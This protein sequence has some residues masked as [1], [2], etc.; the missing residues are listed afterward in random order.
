MHDKKLGTKIPN[1]FQHFTIA[2]FYE[3][4]TD[5]NAHNLT[6]YL[7]EPTTAIWVTEILSLIISLF[8]HAT[9]QTSFARKAPNLVSYTSGKYLD[10]DV[11]SR[12]E[13]LKLFIV[14]LRHFSFLSFDH[15]HKTMSRRH[16]DTFPNSVIFSSREEID[17]SGAFAVTISLLS[18]KIVSFTGILQISE[19]N[20]KHFCHFDRWGVRGNFSSVFFFQLR[21][22]SIIRSILAP[23]QCFVPFSLCI[24]WALLMGVCPL[25][26]SFLA[27]VI[28]QG[29]D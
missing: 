28:M 18:F 23:K 14:G 27:L 8:I 19:Q 11:L 24:W 29:L 22:S 2:R 21:S 20:S 3:L 10:S 9:F 6:R 7:M 26:L 17:W 25:P 1:R 5:W 16:H 13:W 15:A 12:L 4:K